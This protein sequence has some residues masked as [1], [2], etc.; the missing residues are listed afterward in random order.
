M[1]K[2]TLGI[3]LFSVTFLFAGVQAA[4]AN[5]VCNPTYGGGQDC[6]NYTLKIDKQI[7]NPSTNEWKENLN[8][9]DPH[10][11]DQD[12]ITFIIRVT[13]T[14]TT[15]LDT[16]TVRDTIPQFTEY[17]SGGAYD[18]SSRV[19]SYTVNDLMA[20]ETR[21]LNLIVKASNLTFGNT[22]EC[23]VS[24][25]VEASGYNTGTVSDKVFFCLERPGVPQPT[26]PSTP[27]VTTVP[28]TGGNGLVLFGLG[29]L[30]SAGLVVLKKAKSIFK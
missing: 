22:V 19:V 26:N 14:G 21:D 7:Q 4:S 6:K 5:T 11:K 16:V 9:S 20:N 29:G 18:A 3:F 30:F 10:F 28:K 27:Q 17:Y 1:Y 12:L 2:R 8:L 25:Y 13:N 23:N 15:K 24:N